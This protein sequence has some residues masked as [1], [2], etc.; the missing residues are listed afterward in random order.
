MWKSQDYPKTSSLV[1]RLMTQAH[2]LGIGSIWEYRRFGIL[3]FHGEH[4]VSKK[5]IYS[6]AAV[7]GKLHCFMPEEEKIIDE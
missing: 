5:Q 3:C 7:D 4:G 6:N 2:A 1:T